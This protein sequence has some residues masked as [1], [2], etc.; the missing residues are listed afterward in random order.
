MIMIQMLLEDKSSDEVG[1]LVDP[2]IICLCPELQ[3]KLLFGKSKVSYHV[4]FHNQNSFSYTKIL[5]SAV[6]LFFSCRFL[7]QTSPA[8]TSEEEGGLDSLADLVLDLAS[9]IVERSGLLPGRGVA[10]PRART[11]RRHTWAHAGGVSWPLIGPPVLN[12]EL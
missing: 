2:T 8:A 4:W 9:V 5:P 7:S 10:R 3:M 12:T 11:P 6:E 1:L